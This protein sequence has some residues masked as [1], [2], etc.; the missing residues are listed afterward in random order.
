MAIGRCSAGL[1]QGMLGGLGKVRGLLGPQCAGNNGSRQLVGQWTEF[2]VRRASCPGTPNE[3]TA[4]KAPK[5]ADEGAG[6]NA[7]IMSPHTVGVAK[8]LEEFVVAVS[9]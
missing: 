1:H 6:G 2:V 7:V 9:A 4:I 8:P 3:T 5:R